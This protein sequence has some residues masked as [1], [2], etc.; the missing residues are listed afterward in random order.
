MIEE[1]LAEIEI[2]VSGALVGGF[3]RRHRSE[4]NAGALRALI[5]D[6]CLEGT[7]ID[8]IGPRVC[9]RRQYTR[10]ANQSDKL[11]APK[12]LR[13][14]VGTLR[15]ACEQRD[16]CSHEEHE[17]TGKSLPRKPGWPTSEK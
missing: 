6:W 8:A 15:G 4:H 17:N 9:D 1:R 5:A 2:A 13:S 16:Q 11:Q 14:P 7:E 3:E 10:G 12:H